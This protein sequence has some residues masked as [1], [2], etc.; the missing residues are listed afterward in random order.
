MRILVTGTAGF[1]G[2]HLARRLIAEGHEVTGIDGMTA[3]Y[4][5]ALKRARH[6]ILKRHNGFLGHE[7]ML[8]DMP[9][10]AAIARDSQ[11]EA[12]IHL[13]AQAGVRY[14]LE[15]PRDYVQTNLVGTF[16]VLELARTHAVKHLM[17]ASTSSVY[18]GNQAMPFRECE[19]ADHPLT[20]YAATK[21]ATE[22]MSHAYSHLWATP[23]TAFR[24]F[25]VYGPWGRPDMALFKFVAALLEGRPIDVYNNGHMARDFTFIDDLIE[26]IVRLLG[27]P[28]VLGQPAV[29]AADSLSPVAPWRVV[30]IGRGA[31]VSL[32]DFI[33]EVERVTGRTA[34]RNDLPLQP[35][36]P[37]ETF[38]DSSLL[39]ALTGYHP[40]TS[41]R[42]G[43]E[44]FWN[45]Y[46]EHYGVG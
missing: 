11:P 43:V 1:I 14:S 46:R 7:T 10:L 31:P 30:N 22:A 18:G 41:V 26:G 16:N 5:V 40:A 35:G 8:E 12:I 21:K 28:P 13:A 20:M 38:A 25:T 27:V 3:Y 42:E 33:G 6:A 45:W 19:A 34:V 36:D 37:V 32:N 44:A 15:Q 17:L 23:T 9:G 2:F 4:D 39:A 24:F 29:G